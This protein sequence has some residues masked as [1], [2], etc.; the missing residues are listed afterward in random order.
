MSL[1]PPYGEAVFGLKDL[2]LSEMDKT[3]SLREDAIYFIDQ[4]DM[5]PP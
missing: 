3:S 4:E 1:S 5:L 2:I